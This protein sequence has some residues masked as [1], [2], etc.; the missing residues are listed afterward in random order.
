MKKNSTSKNKRPGKSINN[1]IPFPGNY[2]AKQNPNS[3]VPPD[4]LSFTEYKDKQMDI[5]EY[6]TDG[7][8]GLFAYTVTG[9][10]GIPEIKKGYMVFVDPHKKP[11][12]ED[13]TLHFRNGKNYVHQFM[14]GG[15]LI[16]GHLAVYEKT[17]GEK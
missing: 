9:Y 14:P 2:K 15:L 8:E 10:S 1:V 4:D 3:F 13:I 12:P 17:G 7:R 16:I 11:S 5:N 6:L